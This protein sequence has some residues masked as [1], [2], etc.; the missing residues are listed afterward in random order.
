MAAELLL[1]ID[2]LLGDP[3]FDTGATAA[4]VTKK[5]AIS[6]RQWCTQNLQATEEFAAVLRRS[7][8]PALCHTGRLATV[9]SREIMWHRYFTVRTSS[10]FISTWTSFLQRANITATYPALYQHLTDIIFKK[11]LKDKYQTSS[12]QSSSPPISGLDDDALRYA[13]GYV[14]CQLHKKSQ[15]ED[16]RDCLEALLVIEGDSFERETATEWVELLD[17]GGLWKVRE[18]TFQFFH[19]LESEFRELIPELVHGS[20]P[21]TVTCTSNTTPSTSTLFLTAASSSTLTSTPSTSIVSTPTSIASTPSSSSTTSAASV[22]ASTHATLLTPAITLTQVPALTSAYG[23]LPTLTSMPAASSHT[24][25]ITSRKDSIKHRLTSSA[26]V[27]FYWSIASAA[28]EI[29]SDDL[30]SSLLDMITDLFIAMRGN[31]YANAL[32]ERYKQTQ[33]K[34]TQRSKG[35]RKRLYT[36]KNT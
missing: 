22:L 4:M 11:L 32:I 5:S 30:T 2:G 27:Q 7:V 19:A 23:S 29:D 6:L 15:K 36:E 10:E 9:H 1:A 31:S 34:S 20:S 12:L 28:F 26:N 25:P 17:R 14:I 35:I 3:S 18:T 21:S 24:S 13:A 33:K 8:E 16:I